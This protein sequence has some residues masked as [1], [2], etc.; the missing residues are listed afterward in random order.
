MSTETENKY[1]RKLTIL[2]E[3]I[4]MPKKFFDGREFHNYRNLVKIVT[5]YQAQEHEDLFAL[6]E[7]IKEYKKQLEESGHSCPIS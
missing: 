5:T 6:E 2:L 1:P 4:D 7:A 3:A